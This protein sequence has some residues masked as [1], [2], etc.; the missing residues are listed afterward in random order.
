M[1]SWLEK[2]RIEI[3]STHSKGK[4][5]ISERFIRTLKNKIYKYMTSISKSVYIDK[6]DDIVNK[7]NHTYHSTI[8]MKPVDVRSNTYI[9]S[10]KEINDKNAKF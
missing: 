6:F 7:H 5:V 4:T 1:K 10:S 2:N 8:K 3:Y 9:D